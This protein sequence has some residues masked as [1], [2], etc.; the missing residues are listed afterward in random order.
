MTLRQEVEVHEIHAESDYDEDDEGQVGGAVGA[1]P[2]EN[3]P[4]RSVPLTS[5]RQE[6]EIHEI[7]AE[8]DYDEDDEGQVGGAVAVEPF[9][10][11]PHR[12]VP[13][14]VG[15]FMSRLPTSPALILL[16]TVRPVIHRGEHNV[17]LLTS[18]NRGAS[19]MGNSSSRQSWMLVLMIAGLVV[20]YV[21]G[22]QIS[23]EMQI[24]SYDVYFGEVL[25][26]SG[27]LYV[28]EEGLG[29]HVR[30]KATS[31][32]MTWAL[33]LGGVG[34]TLGFLIPL[35]S[36]SAPFRPVQPVRSPLDDDTA[37]TVNETMAWGTECPNCGAMN[38]LNPGDLPSNINCGNCNSNFTPVHIENLSGR[39]GSVK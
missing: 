14:T 36:Q 39:I 6:V 2:F 32:G 37:R 38:A 16:M 26:I 13:L 18:S 17:R 3:L 31:A 30:S 1:E 10:N 21:L 11:L 29:E 7:R 22:Y 15:P 24:R 9:E 4:H 12:S 20:G 19:V 35:K 25:F 23:Y 5:L 8:S 33:V 34:F 27:E 28:A